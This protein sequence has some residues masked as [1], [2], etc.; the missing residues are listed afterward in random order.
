V[1]FEYGDVRKPGDVNSVRKSL[2]STLFGNYVAAGKIKLD[3][4][5]AELEIDDLGG[6][7]AQEKQATVRD[8]LEARSGVFHPPANGGDDSDKA[9]PRGSRARG[10]YFLYNNWDFNALGTIFEQQ[11]GRNLY[12]AFESDLARPL[13]MEDFERRS[14]K[15]SGDLRRSMH[16]AYHFH[17]STR[18]LARVGYL[19]LRQG[20][21]AGQQIVP[22]E[23]VNQ[24]TRIATPVAQ[25]N[26]KSHR[27]GP[28]GYGYLWWVWDK[29]WA[30]GA[31]AGAFTA[32]GMGGQHLSVLP[33]L[34]L[35]VAHETP[36]E[37][38]THQEF[39]ALLETL[40]RARCSTTPC[41][42]TG[43]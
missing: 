16:P 42:P 18:D 24:S 37:T 27:R 29:P 13:G 34:D 21:W 33:A 8:L 20:R 2:L 12:D 1:I 38:G 25:M 28:L 22:R 17:I 10:T 26:T 43:R 14:Q 23:W 11:T 4:T 41:S 36:A 30:V 15:K 6:L 3:A 19:M 32:H 7:S 40:A 31:F 9:P 35:V 5:L 39:W